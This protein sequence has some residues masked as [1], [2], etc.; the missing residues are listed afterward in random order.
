MWVCVCVCVYVCM[1]VRDHLLLRVILQHTMRHNPSLHH[2][3]ND[4]VHWRRE[5]G[6]R[7]ER[8]RRRGRRERGEGGRESKKECPV[9]LTSKDLLCHVITDKGDQTLRERE[10]ERERERERER[11]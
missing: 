10:S 3:H 4:T 7:G 1:C 8:G 11:E 5:R 6:G 9:C 2:T